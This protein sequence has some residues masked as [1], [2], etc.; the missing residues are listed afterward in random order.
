VLCSLSLLLST[1]ACASRGHEIDIPWALTWR[2]HALTCGHSSDEHGI[3]V[4]DLRLF[5]HDIRLVDGS[6]RETSASIIP[7]GHFQVDPVA[8]MD[9]APKCDSTGHTLLSVR[10]PAGA[11]KEVRFKLGVPFDLNHSNPANAPGP[12][13]IAA[14]NW[15]WQAGYKFMRLEG[16]YYGTPFRVHVGSTLCEGTFNHVTKCGHPNI[17]E[18]ELP[19]TP[20][21]VLFDIAEMV[22]TNSETPTSCESENADTCAIPFGSLGLSFSSGLPRGTQHAFRPR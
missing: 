4:E 5:V 16:K 8:M 11:Y 2:T 3:E 19:L 15:D 12:L 13:T 7:D 21:G 10:A 18:V 1:A 17:A 6:G 22:D 14:M 20:A 9:F